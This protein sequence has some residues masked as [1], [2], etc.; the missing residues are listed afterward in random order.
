MNLITNMWHKLKYG[1][2]ARTMVKHNTGYIRRLLVLS[3]NEGRPLNTVLAEYYGQEMVNA[4]FG[5]ANFLGLRRKG[6][7]GIPEGPYHK[8]LARICES[9]DGVLYIRPRKEVESFMD[10]KY[11][12]LWRTLQSIK[13]MQGTSKQQ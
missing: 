10:D 5:Y 3:M 8:Q 7:L 4:E 6:R 12:S 1:N 11:T 2:A 13:A 9:R